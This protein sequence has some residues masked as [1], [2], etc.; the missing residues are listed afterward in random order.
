MHLGEA[1]HAD[2]SGVRSRV[3]SDRISANICRD[4]APSDIW[5]RRWRRRKQIAEELRLGCRAP[6]VTICRAMS[7]AT[8]H[9][10]VSDSPMERGPQEY[11]S[12]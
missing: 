6:S 4:T 8:S 11:R 7:K 1:R 10:Q 3:I 5:S 12:R 9:T 2:A